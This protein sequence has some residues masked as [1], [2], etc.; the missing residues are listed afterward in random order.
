MASVRNLR[1]L[2][3]ETVDLGAVRDFATSF[4]LEVT[5]RGNEIVLRCEGRDQDQILVRE[6]RHRQFHH[7]E[8]SVL[9]GELDEMAQRIE[10]AG[11]K[12]MDAPADS[13]ESGLWV[14]DPDG[15]AIHIVDEQPAET[16]PYPY[17]PLNQAGRMERVDYAMWEHLPTK[18][19]P[20]RL[21]HCLSFVS[22]QTRAE[23]FYFEALGLRL[24]D[25]IPGKATFMNGTVGD[26][27]VFGVVVADGPG[28]HHA[29][30]EM[31]TIDSIVVG[32]EQMIR[33]GFTDSWGLGRHNLGSNYFHY[34]RGPRNLWF[35]YSCD[36]DQ[37]TEKW[38]PHDY[39]VKPWA[40]GPPAPA[41]FTDNDA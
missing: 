5:E 34:F 23:Q 21:M 8:F 20:R 6:G 40:W 1:H 33:D 2:A 28:L 32:S 9:P 35:E 16:R 22:D 41:D 15:N 39:N 4:G 25:R 37:V 38:E 24:T 29:A 7:I 13:D 36:I 30:W 27:H 10:K 14:Q 3:I 19:S 18:A 26:H 12:L 31:D 17:W 11:V